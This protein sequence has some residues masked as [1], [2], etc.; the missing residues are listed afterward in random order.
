[1]ADTPITGDKDFKT[2]WRARQKELDANLLVTMEQAS[3][4][5]KAK[6][7][8]QKLEKKAQK[9]AENLAKRKVAHQAKV[10][11]KKAEWSNGGREKWLAKQAE[12]KAKALAKRKE[13]S[14][15][16]HSK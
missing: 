12:R 15:K 14:E 10:A 8:A 9:A 3:A 2:D 4:E 6:L 13:A 7:L 16:L 1:M 5:K 11:K